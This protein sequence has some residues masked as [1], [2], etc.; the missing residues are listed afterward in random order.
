MSSGKQQFSGVGRSRPAEGSG[1]N[2]DS[3]QDEPDPS[4]AED[5]IVGEPASLV[6]PERDEDSTISLDL[7]ED[8][9]V[10]V[11]RAP[12][13]GSAQNKSTIMDRRQ[14]GRYELL[15]KLAAGG[16]A[17]LYLGRIDG[18]QN[19]QKTVVIK[20]IHEHLSDNESFSQMFMDEARI[21]ALIHHPNVVQIFDMGVISDTYYIAMEYVHGQDLN[22]ALRAIG[23]AQDRHFPWPIACRIVAD[24]AAGLHSA[25]ETCGLDGQSLG[26]VHRDVSPQNIL[27]SYDGHV[28]VVDFGVAYAADKLNQTAAGTLKG[29]LAYMSP[30]QCEGKT[31]DR[32][33]DVFAL[34]IILWESVCMK[35]LFR[36][37]TEAATI[38]RVLAADVPPPSRIREGIPPD[39][40]GIIQKAL[41]KDPSARYQTAEDLQRAIERFLAVSDHLTGRSE[42]AEL[43]K[44]LF[45]DRILIREQQISQASKD[46]KVRDALGV[47]ESSTRD[48]TTLSKGAVQTMAPT[49]PKRALA[50]SMVVGLVLLLSIIGAAVFLVLKTNAF[51]GS[52]NVQTSEP[53]TAAARKPI[54]P[55]DVSR[56]AVLTF[57][58][59]PKEAS[60]FLNG[61]EHAQTPKAYKRVVRVPLGDRPIEIEIKAKGYAPKSGRV[62]PVKDQMVVVSLMKEGS[63]PMV[64]TMAPKLKTPRIRRRRR[65]RR[66]TSGLGMRPAAR[67]RPNTRP[68]SRRRAMRGGVG[69]VND[70]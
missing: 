28:K 27:I 64:E 2:P 53:M 30:E 49:A 13:G 23:R 15:L 60:L 47:T 57:I 24:A 50:I 7:N 32:R 67:K 1:Q 54:A 6:E 5:T 29:K 61:K 66:S 65:R 33:A 42:V 36:E 38:M 45:H 44:R 12:S 41:A 19:F 25:H 16:M 48:E 39:L 9:I 37:E 63:A 4:I 14:F 68:P 40:E 22:Q 62:L 55:K 52:P 58:I 26:L 17:T 3:V 8:A 10:E 56:E 20:M 34:G 59:T 21:S 51:G 18:P 31:L 11:S 70:F 46:T 35:R 69:A 43:M